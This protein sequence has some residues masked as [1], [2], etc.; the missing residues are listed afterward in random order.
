MAFVI[1]TGFFSFFLPS[2]NKLSMRQIV[3]QSD[4][5]S[6]RKLS[7]YL[8]TKIPSLNNAE[9]KKLSENHMGKGENAGERR[10]KMPFENFIGKRRKCW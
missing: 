5:K 7:L 10:E 6:L 8:H 1:S 9:K 4:K 3:K 2:L